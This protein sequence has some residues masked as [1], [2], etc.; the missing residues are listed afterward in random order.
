M[1]ADSNHFSIS[2]QALQHFN[3]RVV[4]RR[5]A[6]RECRPHEFAQIIKLHSVDQNAGVNDYRKRQENFFK[7]CGFFSLAHS[8]AEM[9]ETRMR[10][11][12]KENFYKRRA[13]NWTDNPDKR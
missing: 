10:L 9:V 5:N 7:I 6:R 4:V 8:R 3:R 11:C 2:H 13:M 12:N 1:D